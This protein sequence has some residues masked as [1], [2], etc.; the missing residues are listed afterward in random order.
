MDGF[1][2]RE[3]I[4]RESARFFSKFKYSIDC[5]GVFCSILTQVIL[6]WALY[7]STHHLLATIFNPIW[8]FVC[9]FLC[10]MASWSH[11]ASMTT[12][13]GIVVPSEELSMGKLVMMNHPN[14]NRCT[15]CKPSRT[16]HCSTCEGC[17][18]RMDH[19]CPWINNCVGM[20]NHKHFLLFL[21]YTF[22]Y[23]LIVGFLLGYR[24]YYCSSDFDENGKPLQSSSQLQQSLSARRREAFKA[25]GCANLEISGYVSCAMLAFTCFLFGLFTCIM[26][27]DQ[28]STI[29]E[30]ESRIDRLAAA[31]RQQNKNSN[32]PKTDPY[33]SIPLAEDPRIYNPITG[34]LEEVS[35][36][37]ERSKTDRM[38]EV[39]GHGSRVKMFKF[40]TW[41][42]PTPAWFNFCKLAAESDQ[43]GRRGDKFRERLHIGVNGEVKYGK[44]VSPLDDNAAQIIQSIDTDDSSADGF[45]MQHPAHQHQDVEVGQI[46]ELHQ[47]ERESV[48]RPSDHWYSFKSHPFVCLK[49]LPDCVHQQW[50][51]VTRL[52]ELAVAKSNAIQRLAWERQQMLKQHEEWT[53][54]TDHTMSDEDSEDSSSTH[55]SS[56]EFG[57]RDHDRGRTYRRRA[58]N[59]SRGGLDEDEESHR[60]FDS[61][62][63]DEESGEGFVGK[64][65]DSESTAPGG[66]VMHHEAE[67]YLPSSSGVLPPPPPLPSRTHVFDSRAVH[68]SWEEDR[69]EQVTEKVFIKPHN[70]D[71]G[72]EVWSKDDEL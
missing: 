34:K 22:F 5:A 51:A 45:E 70:G 20:F 14:C 10:F 7:V 60:G 15:A 25:K 56:S 26:M 63:H 53:P 2:S 27:V 18:L 62:D 44:I 36:Q 19:H 3:Q 46:K 4:K 55:S 71:E 17:V 54:R 13:P 43:V 57:P 9:C 11:I 28:I 38:T 24:L 33:A 16:H 49:V 50:S 40:F 30:E 72:D 58:R 47:S 37:P 23:C 1:D 32:L 52:H 41:L 66:V 68:S 12:D 35:S 59:H 6:W 69:G 67:Y 21:F 61:D 39:F 48:L 8:K 64:S 31:K 42:L 29:F 65:Q